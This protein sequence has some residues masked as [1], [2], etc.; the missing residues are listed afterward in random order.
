LS[1]YSP[2]VVEANLDAFEAAERWRPVYHSLDQVLEFKS[3]IDSITKVDSNIRNSYVTITRKLT[4]RRQKEIRRWVENEQVLCSLDSGYFERIYAYICDEKGEIFKFLNRKSQDVFDSILEEF[5]DKQVAIELLVLKARQVGISTKV[6][7]KFLQRLLFIPHTQAVM[8][9]VQSD[10]SELIGRI[11][12][13]CLE[14]C[15]WWL[16]PRQTTSRIKLWGWDNGSILSVQSGMQATGVAQGWTPTCTH[17]SE[18]GDIPNQI[19][20]AHV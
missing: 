7:L 15:P 4:A 20:R 2:R 9:S 6:A 8:A 5:D 17:I 10:K 18:I 19:G 13:I 14:R 12:Q 11:L 1:M 16:I 3:Y